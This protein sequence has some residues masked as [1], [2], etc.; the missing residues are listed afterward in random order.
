MFFGE[1][2]ENGR[3]HVFQGLPRPGQHKMSKN[4]HASAKNCPKKWRERLSHALSPE[5]PI[6]WPFLGTVTST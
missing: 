6:F 1:C 4:D 3:K 2:H 5:N